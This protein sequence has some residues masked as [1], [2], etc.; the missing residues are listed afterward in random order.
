MNT[1]NKQLEIAVLPDVPTTETAA[2]PS[3]SGCPN[4]YRWHKVVWRRTVAVSQGR[5]RFGTRAANNAAWLMLLAMLACGGLHAALAAEPAPQAADSPSRAAGLETRMK[6]VGYTIEPFVL[7]DLHGTERPSSELI[8]KRFSVVAFLGTECPLAKLYAP[9]LVELHRQFASQGVTFIAVNSNRQ[10]S[11]AELQHFARRYKID[12]PLLKDPGNRVADLFDARR[13]PEV[14]V[15]DQ[16]LTV[17]YRGRIDDQYGFDTN[18]RAFARDTPQRRD[19]AVALEELLAGQAVSVPETLPAGCLIG[20]TRKPNPDSP[21]TWSNQ[22]SRVFQRRC[23]TCHRPGEIAPFSLLTYDEVQGWEAMIREVV[24]LGRMPPWH[25]DPQ[26]GEFSNDARLTE[27]EKQQIL[28]WVDNGAPQGDP[29]QLPP[30][31]QFVEGW[32]IGRPDQ[33]VYMSEQPFEVPAEGIVD[34]QWF[35]VD[36]GF[37]EDK[38]VK[39]AEARPG[40]HE[41]VHHVTVYFK[42]PDVPWDLRHNDRIN[43]LGG[44]NPGGGPWTVPPGMAVRIPAGSEIVFEMHYTPNGR[45]QHDRS[46]IGLVFADPHEVTQEVVSVM[47]ANTEFAIPPHA[48]AHRV[49]ASYRLPLDALLLVMRPHMHLRGRSFRYDAQFPDGRVETL[50][51]VPYYDFNWQNN[52]ILKK[53]RR[54]PAGTTIHCVATFDNSADNLANPDPD[55]TVRWGDQ[56]WDE[57]M[58]GI[59]A[60]APLERVAATVAGAP[61][62]DR[63]RLARFLLLIGTVGIVAAAILVLP[64]LRRRRTPTAPSR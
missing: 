31:R 30:P 32:R 16:N 6:G 41:V 34:Y 9:R 57:M 44:F 29:N 8:G 28:A 21:V 51:D 62:P 24:E 12:F 47:I 42:R 59:V 56:T 18:G 48:P 64:G 39:M 58:I 37:T 10:D 54:L 63:G 52:Y 61:S 26:Y 60:L 45:V 19:L 55:A 27:E 35:F 38:W 53:P 33:I 1:S 43:L 3:W 20:R 7:R 50:L 49:E 17:R 22:I 2:N 40:C 11:M 46:C 25:A 15:L 36:P 14:F 23:Q 13:T 5:R 4:S